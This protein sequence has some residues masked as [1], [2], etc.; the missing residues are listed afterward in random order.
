MSQLFLG[1]ASFVYFIDKKGYKVQCH[2]ENRITFWYDTES[3]DEYDSYQIR[4]K[5][6]RD[7]GYVVIDSGSIDDRFAGDD[8]L[9]EALK[10]DCGRLKRITRNKINKNDE[11][12]VYHCESPGHKTAIHNDETVQCKR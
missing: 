11:I 12:K 2:A 1:Y 9:I 8:N 6:K 3:R 10:T 4:G 7:C 5:E